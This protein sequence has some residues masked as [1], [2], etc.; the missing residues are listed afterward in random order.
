MSPGRAALLAAT[1]FAAGCVSDIS[2][3]VQTVWAADL[4]AAPGHTQAG[5]SAAAVSTASR[6]EASILVIGVPFGTYAWRIAEGRCAEPGP[7][8]GADGAYPPV[9]VAD[10]EG[11]S[12]NTLVGAPMLAG[13]RY[14]AEVREPDTEE[15]IACGDFTQR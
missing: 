4:A 5:G 15:R 8:L 6:T 1:L 7:V 3:P 9:E 14:H 13:R 12:L 11:G 2:A 10:P